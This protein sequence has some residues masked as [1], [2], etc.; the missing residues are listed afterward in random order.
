MEPSSDSQECSRVSF[1]VSRHSGAVELQVGFDPF[2]QARLGG[3]GHGVEGRAQGRDHGGAVRQF[4]QCPDRKRFERRADGE[5]VP[6][7]LGVQVPHGQPAPRSGGEQSFLLQ[8]AQGLAERAAADL[9]HVGQFGLHQVLP[10]ASS[11][12]VMAV[13]RAESGLLAE[14]VLFQSEQ[15]GCCSGHG[16]RPQLSMV[17]CLQSVC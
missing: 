13:R 7:F 5:D 1:P 9:E 4:A 10:G 14:A 2:L 15:R 6:D 16:V 11:P 17:D 12:L 3:R 8:L